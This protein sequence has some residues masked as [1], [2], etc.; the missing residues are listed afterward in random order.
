ML[1]TCLFSKALS[2][3]K[4][5][6]FRKIGVY[7]NLCFFLHTVYITFS[8]NVN[9]WIIRQPCFVC[10]ERIF[11]IFTVKGNQSLVILS[12]FSAFISGICTKIKHIPYMGSPDIRSC[13]KLFD[14]FFMIICL[15]FL[16]IIP[17]FRIRGMPV[18]RLTSVL[19]HTDRDIRELF[20]EVIKP[21]SVHGCI[22]AVPSKIMVI[23][24]C[25]RNLN[26]WIMNIAHRNNSHSCQSGFIHLVYHII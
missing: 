11:L 12:V 7:S 13:E 9:E 5:F 21:R 4:Q 25:I 10:I 15:I 17:L 6:Y 18:Q 3:Y 22:S 14:Q 1:R 8:A 2:V 19:T 16:C 24:N 23:R 26:V 20:M